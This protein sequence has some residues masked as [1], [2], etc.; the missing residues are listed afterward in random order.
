MRD[1]L[2]PY[3]AP[4]TVISLAVIVTFALFGA[5]AVGGGRAHASQLT[6]GGT[7]TADT[8]LA[9]EL[10]TWPNNGIGSAAD[11]I[12]LDLNGHLVDG[13]GTP[14]VDCAPRRAICDAGVV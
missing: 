14:A 1:N 9:G 13:D 10:V 11:G 2:R 5:T 3:G 8:T 12:P 6:C 4:V 7:I